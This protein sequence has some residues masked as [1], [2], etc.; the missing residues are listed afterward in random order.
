MGEDYPACDNQ[1]GTI[2]CRQGAAQNA[3]S[4]PELFQCFEREAQIHFHAS[5]VLSAEASMSCSHSFAFLIVAALAA[6]AQPRI[7]PDGVLNSASYAPAGFL[8]SGIAQ[9]SLFVIQGDYLGPDELHIAGPH[10]HLL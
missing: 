4:R 2:G 9:G 1:A 5:H 7:A 10:A 3:E 8:D 6:S